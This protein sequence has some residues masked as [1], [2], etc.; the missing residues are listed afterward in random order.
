M[1]FLLKV[2]TI[3]DS[4][5]LTAFYIEIIC[6]KNNEYMSKFV[7]HFVIIYIQGGLNKIELF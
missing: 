6:I 4:E 5:Y 7:E 3:L 2:H 1:D